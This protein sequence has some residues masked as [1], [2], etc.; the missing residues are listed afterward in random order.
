[1]VTLDPYQHF[2]IAEAFKNFIGDVTY[3]DRTWYVQNE[4][5]NIHI[6]LVKNFTKYLYDQTG[7]LATLEVNEKQHGIVSYRI[8]NIQDICSSLQSK[9]YR[10]K[11]IAE[12]MIL[13]E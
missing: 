2:N 13:C 11:I 6:L 7:L 1:M 12:L 9:T 5:V 3:K 10:D 8:N 4:K